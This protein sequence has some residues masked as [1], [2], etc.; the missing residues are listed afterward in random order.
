MAARTLTPER[1]RELLHYDPA[2][3]VFTWLVAHGRHG[4]FPAGAIAGYK[5][6]KGYLYIWLDGRFY[7]LHRLAWL[8]VHGQWPEDQI[9][10]R[11]TIREHNRIDNLR[12]ATNAQNAQ[13]QHAAPRNNT[14][15][16]TGVSFY[17]PSGKWLSRIMSNGKAIH[18]G[19]HDTMAAA[20]AARLAAKRAYHPFQSSLQ[21]A[22]AP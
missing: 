20:V 2:T 1:L 15:G 7:R 17:K 6:D 10:H 19:Y 11:D 5:N 22:S 9:D 12:P 8:Y 3:G 4:R 18:L 14:T 16:C 13:N 21:G